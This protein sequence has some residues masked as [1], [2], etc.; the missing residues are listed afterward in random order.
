MNIPGFE[1]L[2]LTLTD[3]IVTITL[4]RPQQMNAFNLAM[5]QGLIRALCRRRHSGVSCHW[6]RQGFLRRRGSVIRG[7]HLRL[8]PERQG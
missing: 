6:C 1:T 4:N 7:G 5:M 2:T 8:R 3:A